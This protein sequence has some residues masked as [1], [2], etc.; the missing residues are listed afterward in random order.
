MAAI[1][2]SES[3][4]LEDMFNHV[5]LPPRLPG[6]QDVNIPTIERN[7]VDRFLEATSKLF[8]GTSDDGV[9][10]LRSSLETARRV[11]LNGRLTKASL[12]TAFSSLNY[13][14]FVL[15]HVGQ[16]NAALIIRREKR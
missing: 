10:S 11:N 5:A 3:R 9:S 7:L 1:R 4:F 15:I 14:D 16:Q 8:P 12:I 13:T 6:R 2:S